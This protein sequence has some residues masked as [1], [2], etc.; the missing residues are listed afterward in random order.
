[1]FQLYISHTA[2][3]AS[4]L[5]S[6]PCCVCCCN[7]SS[8]MAPIHTWI[9]TSASKV[10]CM[11]RWRCQAAIRAQLPGPTS[12]NSCVGPIAAFVVPVAA[13]AAE[14][15]SVVP[16]F[17]AV[18]VFVGSFKSFL[19]LVELDVGEF[20][21]KLSMFQQEHRRALLYVPFFVFLYRGSLT[22][23]YHPAVSWAL[24]V[25]SFSVWSFPF[26]STP[27]FSSTAVWPTTAFHISQQN[28]S[29]AT[30]TTLAAATVTA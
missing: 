3:A 12:R 22:G 15:P 4:T 10:G 18:S 1:M 26:P 21:L 8:T 14:G 20:R 2:K 19:E 17:F 24:A 5:S 7:T 9:A 13:T 6:P 11:C 29:W 25:A 27:P 16:V 30:T 23:T 28:I